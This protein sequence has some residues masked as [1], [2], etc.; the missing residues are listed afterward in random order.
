[1]VD[2]IPH[3]DDD[4]ISRL[5]AHYFLQADILFKYYKKLDDERGR[6]GRLSK[7]KEIDEFHLR[8]LWLAALYVIA[9][10][11][12]A[13]LIQNTLTR[14]KEM[15][16]DISIHCGSIKHKMDQL[17]NELR[18]FRNATFHYQPSPQ[19]H[20]QFIQ[21]QGRH[22]PLFW[23]EELHQEFEKLFSEYRVL[24]FVEYAVQEDKKDHLG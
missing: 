6:K 15:S 9:E 20:L 11:F 7:N 4:P 17:G 2:K 19:K 14:W 18:V 16:L 1:M 5:Y 13:P 3:A 10:G 8:K 23:A 22:K 24:H 21:V 12:E